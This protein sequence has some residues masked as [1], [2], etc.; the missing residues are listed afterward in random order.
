MT[1]ATKAD[2]AVPFNPMRGK[3]SL[4]SINSGSSTAVITTDIAWNFN[5]VNESPAPRS[6]EAMRKKPNP[7]GS[8]ER[9]GADSRWPSPSP[10]SG[11]CIACNNVGVAQIPSS[12]STKLKPPSKLVE[13]CTTR[14]TCAHSFAPQYCE[15]RILVAMVNPMPTL[16]KRKSTEKPFVAAVNAFFPRK[17]PTHMVLMIP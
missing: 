3:P 2:T 7:Q 5:G 16:I 1:W 12:I 10:R 4:P 6:M 17:L 15:M 8:V 9:K 11:V 13:L 14:F